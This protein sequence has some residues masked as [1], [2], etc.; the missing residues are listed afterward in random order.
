MFF[1][2]FSYK[3]VTFAIFVKADNV[4]TFSIVHRESLDVLLLTF[5]T[6]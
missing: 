2:Y 4:K 3:V 5:L 1:C 6:K